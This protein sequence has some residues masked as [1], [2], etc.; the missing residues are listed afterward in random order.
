MFQNFKY[1]G[2]I[3]AIKNNIQ[4]EHTNEQ[5]MLYKTVILP[6]FCEFE[7]WSVTHSDGMLRTM[8]PKFDF[9]TAVN[10][11]IVV[12]WVVTYSLVSGYQRFGRMYRL[13]LQ[14]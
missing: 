9:L 12:F 8:D 1:L 4:N 13:H 5:N 10:L 3:T 7:T 2:I 14:G 11:L 6:H